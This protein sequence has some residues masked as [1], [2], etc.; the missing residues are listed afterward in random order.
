MKNECLLF[1]EFEKLNKKQ[2]LK[3][4]EESLDNQNFIEGLR[5]FFNPFLS[6]LKLNQVK[7]NKKVWL[8]KGYQLIECF[9]KYDC[10][11]ESKL[12]DCF[13]VCSEM[14]YKIFTKTLKT[15]LKYDDVR[16]I[17]NLPYLEFINHK[18][19]YYDILKWGNEVFMKNKTKRFFNKDLYV[20]LQ[21]LPFNVR[22]CY[23]KQKELI[24]VSFLNRN[25]DIVLNK[26]KLLR[27]NKRF[28]RIR[29]V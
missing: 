16:E 11:V 9:K 25:E 28:E 29:D 27:L 20:R 26:V 21:K 14:Y 3:F 10:D 1:K 4:I 12:K 2:Q 5:V 13:F 18:D 24:Y 8:N 7:L 15:N 6:K 23:S 22:L 19:I 17:L